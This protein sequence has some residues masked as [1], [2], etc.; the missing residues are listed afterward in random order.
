[1]N[2]T[3]FNNSRINPYEK[4]LQKFLHK[5][6]QE[7]LQTFLQKFLQLFMQGFRIQEFSAKKN[8]QKLAENFENV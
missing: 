4:K 3:I 1:M 2:S 5:K 7:F 8:L 6:L